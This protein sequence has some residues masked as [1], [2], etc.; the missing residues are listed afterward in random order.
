M[1][2]PE[3]LKSLAPSSACAAS[4][5]RQTDAAEP[6]MQYEDLGQ[7]REEDWPRNLHSLQEWI[8]ELLIRN[9][10]LRMSLLDSAHNRKS[11]ETD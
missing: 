4:A 6:R 2:A 9:Q 11:A 10:E 3:H 5:Q 8:C 1:F 7:E